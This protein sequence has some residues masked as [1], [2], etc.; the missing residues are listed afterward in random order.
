[1]LQTPLTPAITLPS[2]MPAT[3]SAS[4]ADLK[5]GLAEMSSMAWATSVPFIGPS[6]EFQ[7]QWFV[8]P[9][10]FSPKSRPVFPKK[11]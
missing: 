7:P 9:S 5:P 3:K 11:E 10:S 6:A 1:M 2:F 8:T 4:P